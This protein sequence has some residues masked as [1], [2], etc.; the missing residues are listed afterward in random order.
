MDISST[1]L[2]VESA[3]SSA[4]LRL[5]DETRRYFID[6]D[7]NG[8]R[9]YLEA[10]WTRCELGSLVTSEHAEAAQTA[11]MCL[12]LVGKFEDTPALARGLHHDDYFVVTTAEQA[13]WAVWLRASGRLCRVRLRRAIESM[14]AGDYA[15][16]ERLLDRVLID[17]PDFVEGI[18]QR[19]ILLY[20]TNRHELSIMACRRTL[21]LNPHH[22]GAASGLGHNHFQLGQYQA[23]LKA[24]RHTLAIHPRK[25]G[26]RQM[27]R[28]AKE[29]LAEGAAPVMST[30][31]ID[32]VLSLKDALKAAKQR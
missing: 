8:L 17:D 30:P 9:T 25:D 13:L 14:N 2:L 31:I 19:A 18:N 23:A 11:A 3:S 29:A 32:T 12:G 27:M 6:R 15:A 22:F 4:G 16:A 28:R 5:I 1:T 21:A 26:V 7:E 20:L 10:R 24:Y